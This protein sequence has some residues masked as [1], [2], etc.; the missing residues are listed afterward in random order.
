[1]HSIW[2]ITKEAPFYMTD[3]LF[4]ELQS[5]NIWRKLKNHLK[6]DIPNIPNYLHISDSNL[7]WIPSHRHQFHHKISLALW[8]QS[9]PTVSGGLF[10]GTQ[11][12]H[13]S[14]YVRKTCL[15]ELGI[16]LKCRETFEKFLAACSSSKNT[17]LPRFFFKAFWQ[18]Y[19][20]N[21]NFL[22]KTKRCLYADFYKSKSNYDDWQRQAK[23]NFPKKVNPMKYPVHSYILVRTWNLLFMYFTGIS[24]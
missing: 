5:H 21:N 20:K 2:A 14:E 11:K 23:P 22:T 13:I 24:H 4:A 15:K 17:G 7:P 10:C 19:F 12:M 18:L 3:V 8:D 1:M 9:L 16:L 6:N